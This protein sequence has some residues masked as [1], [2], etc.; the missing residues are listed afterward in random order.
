ME[1]VLWLGVGALVIAFGCIVFVG[2]PFVPSRRRDVAAAFDELCALG[3]NDVAVDLGAGSG[4]VLRAA[5]E[6]G[7]GAVGFELNPFL[8][9]YARLAL[10]RYPRVRVR[11]ANFLTAPFPA[12]TTVVYIFGDSRDMPKVLAHIRRQATRL[13]RPLRVVSY[14]FE[15]PGEAPTV[16]NG[17]HHLYT[18]KPLHEK[19]A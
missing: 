13:G 7:A 10:R 2:P 18:I 12:D 14:G 4:T 9:L 19:K 8:V 1:I 6:R 5:A 11:V 16:Q 17:A 3:K 15:L